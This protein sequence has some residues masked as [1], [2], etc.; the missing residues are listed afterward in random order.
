MG[1]GIR[2]WLLNKICALLSPYFEANVD[3]QV[4]HALTR[5]HSE[6]TAEFLAWLREQR[7][8][9]RDQFRL[10]EKRDQLLV[11]QTEALE[12]LVARYHGQY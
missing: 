10:S 2:N 6:N 9:E 7:G 3:K 1:F 5:Y 12:T 4:S 11:R 8:N